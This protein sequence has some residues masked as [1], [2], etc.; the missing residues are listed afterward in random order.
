MSRI[1]TFISLGLGLALLSA[2][3][4]SPKNGD[5]QEYIQ[6][7]K[8]RP[9]GQVEPL[10]AFQPYRPF[11]YSAMQMRSPFEPPAREEQRERQLSG[12]Q[13]QPDL[14]REKE[15]LENFNVATLT[16]VGTLTKDGQLW[17]LID[18]GSGGIHSVTEGNYMGKNHGRIVEASRT[19]LQL[20]E[21]VADGANGWVERP[22]IIELQ[23][24]E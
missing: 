22:R 15:Y 12:K 3:S 11:T 18:D 9:A 6:E 16:M 24:K 2:C 7:T 10:P 17:A 21:I 20:L 8:D 13:V 5:L 4:G 1:I 19:E 14:N 23:E